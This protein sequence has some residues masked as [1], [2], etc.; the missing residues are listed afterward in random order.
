MLERTLLMMSGAKDVSA[1]FQSTICIMHPGT[2]YRERY[3]E[4]G[5]SI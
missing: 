2:L 4:H 3:T 5:N 1:S